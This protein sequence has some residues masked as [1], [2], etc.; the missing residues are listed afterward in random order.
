MCEL[1]DD[2]QFEPADFLKCLLRWWYSNS[3]G[4][5]DDARARGRW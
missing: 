4:M 5:S 3:P 1:R 2:A